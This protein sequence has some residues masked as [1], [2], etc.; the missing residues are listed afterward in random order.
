MQ[1]AQVCFIERQID[2]EIL[3]AIEIVRLLLPP[4]AVQRDGDE[5]VTVQLRL[6][7]EI[8]ANTLQLQIIRRDTDEGGQ[9]RAGIRESK[10]TTKNILRRIR[11]GNF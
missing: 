2:A 5:N 8:E 9:F 10:F 7:V 1:L 11:A 3:G 6:S 4:P